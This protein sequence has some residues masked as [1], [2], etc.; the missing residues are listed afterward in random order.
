MRIWLATHNPGKVKEFRSLLRWRGVELLPAPADAP[1]PPSRASGAI[2][3]RM[4]PSRRLSAPTAYTLSS[5]D[6]SMLLISP[7]MTGTTIQS[8]RNAPTLQSV[9]IGTKSLSIVP[10]L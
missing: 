9:G 1:Q 4:P 2:P 7:A 3:P 8:I 6:V 5:R 10:T